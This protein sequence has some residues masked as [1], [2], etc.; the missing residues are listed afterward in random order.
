MESSQLIYIMGA[1]KRSGTNF[2]RDLICLHPECQFSKV[3]E[4]FLVTEAAKLK[5]FTDAVRGRWGAN[6]KH[7][8]FHLEDCM[9]RGL[10]QFI[11]GISDEPHRV[12]KSPSTEGLPLCDWMFPECK[13][14]IIVRD[15]RDTLESGRQTFDWELK[16]KAALWAASA[17]RILKFQQENPGRAHIVKYEDLVLNLRPTMQTLLSN[18]DL[19]SHSY[20]FEIAAKLPLRGSCDMIHLN[21]EMDWDPRPKH[22]GFSPIGR[23]QKG[24]RA[25]SKT[26]MFDF[27]QLAGD[28]NRMF[29]YK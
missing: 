19:R 26:D 20:D 2:L 4:D 9:R 14:V 21:G 5:A 7:M 25:W 24:K 18:L 8:G 11:Q 3:P 29:G 16:K 10:L 27:E 22:E 23:W 12:C 17:S 1:F 13:I 6:W 28:R 15:A